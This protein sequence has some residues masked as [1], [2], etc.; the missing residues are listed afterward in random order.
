MLFDMTRLKSLIFNIAFFMTTALVLTLGTASFIFSR[1]IVLHV[2]QIWS[3]TI[4]WLLKTIVGLDYQVKGIEKLTFPCIIASK[5]QSS[6]ET[7]VYHAILSDPA[8]VLKKELDRLTFGGYIRRLKMIIVDRNG[9]RSALVSMLN[10]AKE[11]ATS[12]RPI[13]IF[14]EGTRSKVGEKGHYQKGVGLL[15][16]SLHIPVYPVAL[17]SG[18]FWGRRAFDKKPGIIT[19]DILD[20][21]KPGMEVDTF[22]EKLEEEVEGRSHLLA[23]SS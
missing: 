11:I 15:Y 17:N 20:A 14:P 19:L 6:W 16:K 7:I 21:L 1:S 3:R 18:C 23:K 22:M 5:H 12:G 10:Q 8:Y 2:T 13:I 4:L 9:G